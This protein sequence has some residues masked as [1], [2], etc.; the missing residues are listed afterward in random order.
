MCLRAHRRPSLGRAAGRRSATALIVAGFVA[1]A[2][3]AAPRGARADARPNDGS[4]Y[5]GAGLAG[6]FLP[7]NGGA[8]A[9][10][11]PDAETRR[12]VLVY[13][14]SAR[15]GR[16]GLAGSV[17][18]YTVTKRYEERGDPAEIKW[19]VF[20]VS[21]L[22]EYR[23]A[24]AGRPSPE[25]P[26]VPSVGLRAG[27]TVAPHGYEVSGRNARGTFFTKDDQTRVGPAVGADLLWP[28]T[29]SRAAFF[30]LVEKGFVTSTLLTETIEIGSLRAGAGV[31]WLFW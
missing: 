5:L 18:R 26:R 24:I 14:S 12:S 29:G 21:A 23:V 1:L 16:L 11:A 27:A 20:E 6:Q 13:L 4:F 9:V 22:A 25:R 10:L 17:A 30:V 8:P 15:A 19:S 31:A 7:A 3:A 28:L 2:A